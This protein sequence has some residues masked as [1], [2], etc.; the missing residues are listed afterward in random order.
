MDAR[1]RRLGVAGL[2]AA[3]VPSGAGGWRLAAAARLASGRRGPPSAVRTDRRRADAVRSRGGAGLLDHRG[4]RTRRGCRAARERGQFHDRAG[5]CRP[6]R[7]CGLFRRAG[8]RGGR[9]DRRDRPAPAGRARARAQGR[10]GRG[11]GRA[12]AGDRAA[13]RRGGRR[14]QPIPDGTPPAAA[15]VAAG[16][17]RSPGRGPALRARRRGLV[18]R[19]PDRARAGRARG[20]G[21]ARGRRA[22]GRADVSRDARFDGRRGGH[23]GWHHAGGA[24]GGR[25]RPRPACPSPQ[26][27]AGRLAGRA[28][29]PRP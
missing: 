22:R 25:P 3:L 15:R 6:G 1:S 10:A 16:P 17:A 21:A 14:E 19:R 26:A 7:G 24:R 27:A 4:E 20:V 11:V 2:P 29:R 8:G 5:P 9:D 13:R 28:A 18:L 23:R 12:G